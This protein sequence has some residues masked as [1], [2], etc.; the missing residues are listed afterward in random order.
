MCA[1][2][3]AC[4]GAGSGSRS[5]TAGPR[6]RRGNLVQ[7]RS[8]PPLYE[9]P[10]VNAD[11]DRL[12]AAAKRIRDRPRLVDLRKSPESPYIRSA[13]I[14]ACTHSRMLGEVARSRRTGP[15]FLAAIK[16]L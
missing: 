16:A 11:L 6:V 7:A 5:Q 9:A 15:I 1:S 13:R 10:C 14:G 12:Q 3:R 4:A 2:P 8:N